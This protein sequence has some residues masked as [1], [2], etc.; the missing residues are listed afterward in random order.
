MP[1]MTN[2]CRAMPTTTDTTP[3]VAGPPV[4][5][6]AAEEN[7]SRARAKTEIDQVMLEQMIS[8]LAPTKNSQT[9][10]RMERFRFAGIRLDGMG[11]AV[12]ILISSSN[13]IVKPPVFYYLLFIC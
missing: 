1:T 8:E 12:P 4:T 2:A 6:D 3:H 5:A 13:G 9:V 11:F 10:L 7:P